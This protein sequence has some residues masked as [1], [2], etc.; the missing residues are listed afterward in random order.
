MLLPSVVLAVIGILLIMSGNSIRKRG[1]TSFIAGNNEVFI[2]KN[3]KKLA[4]RIGWLLVSFGYE[5][6]AFPIFFYFIKILEGYH[7][8]I[9]AILHLATVFIFMLMDQFE[10]RNA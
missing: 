8:A 3:E 1:K 10:A 2:P 9:L 6:V 7:F 4:K 5:T